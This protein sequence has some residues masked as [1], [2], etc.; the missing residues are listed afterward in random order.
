MHREAAPPF[1]RP[2]RLCRAVAPAFLGALV[3]VGL[4]APASAAVPTRP[5]PAVAASPSG[6]PGG[7]EQ[8]SPPTPAPAPATGT[9][10]PTTPGPTASPTSPAPEVTTTPQTRPAPTEQATPAPRTAS[11][12]PTTVPTTAPPATTPPTTTPPTTAPPT[13]ATPTAPDVAPTAGTGEAHDGED[14]PATGSAAAP[15]PALVAA[16]AEAL[17]TTAA[18]S[19]RLAA[20]SA[21]AGAALE[22]R[23]TAEE[24]RTAALAEKARQ[25]RVEKAARQALAHERAAVGRWASTAYRLGGLS[26]SPVATALLDGSTTDEVGS[27]LALLEHVGDRRHVLLLDAAD[28]ER[29]AERAA[30]AAAEAARTADAEAATAA[31]QAERAEGLLAQQREL[32]ASLDAQLA[33]ARTALASTGAAGAAAAE[34]AEAATPASPVP[35][36]PFVGACTGEDV[37][38]YG[39]GQIPLSALCPLA[40]AP[41]EHL[42]AD[43]AAAFDAMSHSYEQ[44]FG[45]PL[46]V[47]DSYR[48]LDEQ[49]S[50]RARK[51]ALAAVPGTS[52]HG[53]GTALDLCGG[54]DDFTTPQH[55]WLQ[56]RAPLFGWFQPAWAQAH[57]DKPEPWH[58]QFAGTTSGS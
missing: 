16:Y 36:G 58:W 46:C 26:Q 32:V 50:I 52:H 25:E 14:R 57:G 30:A 3:A 55:A 45:V 35:A 9:T 56:Q 11:P 53:L 42:R 47:T 24:R 8:T 20:L 40:D 19:A 28:T 49:Y 17:K 43:A 23:E 29:V 44:T 54:I 6:E 34:A 4:A 10:S 27:Q 38:G 41:G 51:P 5:G 7:V 15:D 12:S 33:A 39:N 22:A 21:Q 1:H 37:T 18:A 2:T 48:S 31:E 13:T